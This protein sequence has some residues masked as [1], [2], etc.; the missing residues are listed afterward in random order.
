MISD[1]VFN[2]IRENGWMIDE[3]LDRTL[4][5]YTRID[6][7]CPKGHIVQ[8][9]VTTLAYSKSVC[10]VCR[11]S[12]GLD[13]VYVARLNDSI[14]K[15]GIAKADRVESRLAEVHE[16]LEPTFTKQYAH[17]VEARRV[18]R[19]LLS[20]FPPVEVMGVR[21]GK[22]EFRLATVEEVKK[23]MPE[24]GETDFIAEKERD[25]KLAFKQRK[26]ERLKQLRKSNKLS[27]S[28]IAR[29]VYVTD[30]AVHKWLTGERPICQ[31]RLELLEYKLGVKV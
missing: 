31:A 25:E 24:K 20:M 6:V 2:R 21:D 12:I 3:T 26:I 18:E 30:S 29:L 8:K 5:Q 13:T 28:D 14:V 11:E 4:P 16:N 27:A 10:D 22:T 1:T 19:Y 15:I 17:D 7:R 9:A 23:I